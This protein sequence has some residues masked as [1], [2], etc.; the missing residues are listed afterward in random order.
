MTTLKPDLPRT[1]ETVTS[2]VQG[3]VCENEASD[4]INTNFCGNFNSSDE[5]YDKVDSE[6]HFYVVQLA[7]YSSFCNSGLHFYIS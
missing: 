7:C 2:D 5:M 3:Q 4:D 1:T 6:E